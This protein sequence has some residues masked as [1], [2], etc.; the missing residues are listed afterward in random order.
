VLD[1]S[2]HDDLRELSEQAANTPDGVQ[3]GGDC[4]A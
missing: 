4:A 2:L 3:L 1:Q